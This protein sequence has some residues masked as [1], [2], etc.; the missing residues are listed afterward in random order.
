MWA[1]VCTPY[2]IPKGDT[3][4]IFSQ[5]TVAY[6]SSHHDFYTSILTH[7]G[8]LWQCYLCRGNSFPR[9]PAAVYLRYCGPCI[10]GIPGF[11][12]ISNCMWEE[13]HWLLMHKCLEFKIL[14]CIR[15]C[16]AGCLPSYLRELCISVS[17]IPGAVDV[18]T[19][20]HKMTGSSLVQNRSFTVVVPTFWNRLVA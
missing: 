13:L 18:F 7:K 8:W 3:C 10:G 12:R 19:R 20:L 11:G 15:N 17:S 5:Y 1:G 2:T 14:M 9:K 4:T 16:T 6:N